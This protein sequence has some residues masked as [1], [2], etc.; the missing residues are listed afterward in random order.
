MFSF[1]IWTLSFA[2]CLRQLPSLHSHK[3]TFSP[4]I[5]F[6]PVIYPPM[7]PSILPNIKHSS[8]PKQSLLPPHYPVNPFTLSF[9]ILFLSILSLCSPAPSIL[10]PSS[11][12][13]P[14]CPFHCVPY[15]HIL[16]HP[17]P[18]ILSSI[19]M[20][21]LISSSHPIASCPLSSYP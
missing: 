11:I 21:T 7:S 2:S 15:P 10:L 8:S 1:L 4:T 13:L 19:T 5:P 14:S 12:S 3:E 9:I 18:F 20:S 6:P 16:F 17:S